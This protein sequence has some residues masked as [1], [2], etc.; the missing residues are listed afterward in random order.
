MNLNQEH[1][2]AYVDITLLKLLPHPPG[3][4]ELNLYI[5]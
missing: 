2:S 5:Q 1:V 3:V 4:N